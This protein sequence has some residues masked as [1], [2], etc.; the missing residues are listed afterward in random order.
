MTMRIGY[1]YDIHRLVK[2]R[3]LIIGGVTIPFEKGLSGHSDADVMAHAVADAL[4]GAA[5]LGDIGEHFP[6]TDDKYKEFN[7]ML[8]LREIERKVHFEKLEIVNIDISLVLQ[9]PKIS[10][11]KE[12][13]KKNIAANLF[14]T[15]DQINVKAT[16]AENLGFIGKGKGVVCYAA[17]LLKSRSER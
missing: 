15:P 11:Y 6:D 16:T 5:G 1:G 3:P 14:I 2:G 12:Q 17:A 4:L 13:M 9:A 10:P 8:F 7:S